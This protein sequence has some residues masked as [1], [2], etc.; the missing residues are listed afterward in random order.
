MATI[1][2]LKRKR[3][4]AYQLGYMDPYTGRRVRRTIWASRKEAELIRKKIEADIALGR[5]GLKTEVLQK[6]YRLSHLVKKYSAHSR[7]NKAEQTYQREK[8][9][10]KAFL[11]FMGGGDP[12]L[13]ELTSKAIE[14]YRQYRLGKGLSPSTVGIEIRH[15]KAMFNQGVSWGMLQKNPVIGVRQPKV[16]D[17]RVR[18]LTVDEID[19]LL[20]SIS[21]AGEDDFL[22]LIMAYLHTGARRS[23]LLP[24]V[25]TWARVD[26][27]NQS[28][29]LLGKGNKERYI[30]MNSTLQGILKRRL[31]SGVNIPFDF[32]P[33]F[34]T[35]RVARYYKEAGITGA[36]LHSLRKT[37]GSILLQQK[38]ADIYTISKLLG[39]A[40]IQTSEKF[41]LELLDENYRASVDGLD[42]IIA[43]P[44]QDEA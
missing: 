10:I 35:H 37:F 2:P 44:T 42:S 16:N 36:N 40:S 11:A 31:E 18:Y 13:S 21:R 5:F 7:S 22:D 15:L 29:S 14:N 1:K 30:P 20:N 39:H 4:E 9:V 23:E 28:I 43:S 32:K 17:R 26:F 6:R 41:Y 12:H 34:V 19:T 8:Y 25:F 24:P 27:E 3:G 33:D 38:K